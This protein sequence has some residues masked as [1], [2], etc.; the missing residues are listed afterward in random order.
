MGT[1]A[2]LFVA[3]ISVLYLAG[4]AATY[5]DSKVRSEVEMYEVV[6]THRPGVLPESQVVIER[7]TAEAMA[8]PEAERKF[9]EAAKRAES[10]QVQVPKKKRKGALPAYQGYT[11]IAKIKKQRADELKKKMLALEQTVAEAATGEL[12]ALRLPAASRHEASIAPT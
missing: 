10:Q 4:C 1:L 2:S 7:S 11:V 8:S 9:D 3:G 12:K 6:E 5:P